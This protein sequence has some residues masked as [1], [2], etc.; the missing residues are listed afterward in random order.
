MNAYYPAF[1]NLTARRCLVVGGGQVAERKIISLIKAGG[2]VIVVSPKITDRIKK[3]AD[4]GSIK[5]RLR[6]YR[7]S[8]M[9]GVFLAIAATDSYTDNKKISDDAHKTNILINVVDTPA[10]CSF[11]VP[12]TVS[13]GPLTIAISTSGS[14]PAVAK[15]I[16]K[17]LE[18]L[19]GAEFGV[20]L[21]ELK[22]QREE[23]LNKTQDKKE[24]ERLLNALVP[25]DI[26]ER[27]RKK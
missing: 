12:S 3:E 15:T 8:D 23:I 24:R 17:E 13:R 10:L 21:T 27:I 22:R 19:Y 6:R 18:G 14:S 20:Y 25:K 16:R 11:I 1:I 26:L 4:K 7:S 9:K 2:D 5:V